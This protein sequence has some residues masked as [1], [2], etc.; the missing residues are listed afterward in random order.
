[1][2]RSTLIRKAGIHARVSPL[3]KACL[4][5]IA[6]V[7]SNLN[8]FGQIQSGDAYTIVNLVSGQAVDDPSAS[9]TAGQQMQEWACN[10]YPQ[11]NWIFYENGAGPY[12][13]IV[14]EAS[15]LALSN[16]GSQSNGGAIVQEP[17]SGST[18]QNW[19]LTSVG[20][21]FYN[22]VNENSGKVLDLPSGNLNNGTLLQQWAS[23]GYPQQNW[24]ITS[25]NTCR[26]GQ[27][28][29]TTTQTVFETAYQMISIASPPTG[30]NN[31][32][33]LFGTISLDNSE[34]IFAEELF[35]VGIVAPQNGACPTALPPEPDIWTYIVKSVTAGTTS[36][37]I[38]YSPNGG[39]GVPSPSSSATCLGLWVSGG[40]PAQAHTVTGTLN[41][42]A[43][44][45]PYS[46]TWQSA[47]IG[48]EFDCT[49][50]GCTTTVT[51][52]NQPVT[53][54]SNGAA[55]SISSPSTLY[56]LW[57]DISNATY[58]LPAPTGA[59]GTTNN[60]YIG[61]DGV[62]P[63]EVGP[64]GPGNPYFV[65]MTDFSNYALIASFPQSGNGDAVG[66]QTI[67]QTFADG[68]PGGGC[69]VLV[70]GVSSDPGNAK[71]DNELQLH[72][73]IK[74]GD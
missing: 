32:M 42:A 13:I 11:Q 62:C 67:F 28:T 69:L 41:L 70:T 49:T 55:W 30:T 71:L 54:A 45:A 2:P 40:T 44:T 60:L 26:T 74:P 53:F 50:S 47:D 1:M 38:N 48:G 5:A 7:A 18:T 21:G 43:I 36:I 24:Y 52:N 17:R 29:I 6:F 57:G 64:F 8:L 9:K 19:S 31:L 35:V 4:F 23:D 61:N 72:M 27:A 37:P 34:A 46:D 59:W 66:Q 51:V 68:I 15:G 20:N 56:I 10:G 65:N 16:N 3:S 25:Q 33:Q 14:N 39:L 73:V 12:W 22:L 63:A 58:P